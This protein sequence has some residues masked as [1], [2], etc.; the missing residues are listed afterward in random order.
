MKIITKIVLTGGPCGGKSTALSRIEQA[1]T[2]MGYKVIIVSETASDLIIGGIPF[3]SI[4]DV[5]FQ[6]A[7]LSLM[8][9]RE[10]MFENCAKELPDEKILI[11]C[12]RGALDNKAYLSSDDFNKLMEK[13]NTNEIELM[14]NYDAVFHLVSPA[15]G[16]EEYYTTANNQ[17]RTES[18][19]HAVELDRLLIEAWTGHPHFRVID[20][21]TGFEEKLRRLFLEISHF[22]GRPD[23]YEV[24][25]K[26]LINYPNIELLENLPNCQKTEI[27]QTYLVSDN[28]EMEL[29]IRQVG[30][31]GYYTYTKA[32]KRKFINTKRVEVEKRLRRSEYL[33]LLMNADTTLH[34]IRKTRYCLVY[35]RQYFE[36]DI[37]PFWKNQAIIKIELAN[38]PKKINFPDFI[39]VLREVT[40]DTRYRN[41]SLA[42]E[43]P[44]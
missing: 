8:L 44:K 24:E 13:L 17:A 1:Y 6:T 38:E 25:R 34:Q 14:G 16:A 28:S 7:V 3:G 11:V 30:F 12:D 29:R 42:K 36:V 31:D 5:E 35:D 22:L 43:Y 18:A 2:G 27:I 21:S 40:E 9:F 32:E 10:K 15:D 37:Y 33:T 39:T 20:N 23:S 4:P 19:K 26:F 41:Y